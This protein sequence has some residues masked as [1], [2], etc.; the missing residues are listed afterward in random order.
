MLH[1]V[2]LMDRANEIIKENIWRDAQDK[3][4][5]LKFKDEKCRQ[6]RMW[7]ADVTFQAELYAI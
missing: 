3:K 7:A 2:R 1:N 6:Q 5:G 4:F